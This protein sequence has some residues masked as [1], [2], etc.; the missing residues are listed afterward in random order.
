MRRAAKPT[1]PSDTPPMLGGAKPPRP[2]GTPPMLGGAKPP[3]PSGTPP[4]LGRAKPPRPSDTPPMLGGAKAALPLGL[5][6]LP[7]SLL[8]G[9]KEVQPDPSEAKGHA[10]NDNKFINMPMGINL[11]QEY[12][13]LL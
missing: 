13:L 6:D 10:L 9:G 8:I 12:K 1:R 5:S 7:V 3:R 11:F 2:S 4:M